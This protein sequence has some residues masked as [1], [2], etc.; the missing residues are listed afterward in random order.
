ME[1]DRDESALAA[2]LPVLRLFPLSSISCLSK[3]TLSTANSLSPT[4][5][6]FFFASCSTEPQ[7][8]TQG[9]SESVIQTMIGGTCGQG[10]GPPCTHFEDVELLPLVQQVKDLVPVDFKTADVQVDISV[11]GAR[12]VPSHMQRQYIL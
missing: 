10:G 11:L 3:S 4:T 1:C 7:S 9:V 5:T 6:T 8:H 2:V 12:E